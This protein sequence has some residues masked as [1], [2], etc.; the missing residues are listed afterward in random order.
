MEKEYKQVIVVRTDLSMTGGKAAA[1]VAHASV[2]SVIDED[3]EPNDA[4]DAKIMAWLVQGMAKAVVK[5][6]GEDGLRRLMK[7]ALDLGIQVSPVVDR[8]KTLL[9]Q[10]TLTC[11]AFGPDVVEVLDQVTGKLE[12]L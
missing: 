8:G 10:N 2:H 5:V 9:P 6:D 4:R 1:Q 3:E 7:Q 12:L 11:A